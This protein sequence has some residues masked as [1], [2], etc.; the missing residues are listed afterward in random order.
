M[1][2]SVPAARSQLM[3]QPPS[4]HVHERKWIEQPI[5]GDLCTVEVTEAA[6]IQ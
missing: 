5:R 3:K 2:Q 6:A 1:Q 4:G